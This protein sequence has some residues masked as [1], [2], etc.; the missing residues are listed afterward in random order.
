MPHL[1][2]WLRECAARH[3]RAAGNQARRR[4][5]PRLGARRARLSQRVL[6][7]EDL[8]RRGTAEPPAV[9]QR[10]HH[11][12]PELRRSAEA[13]AGGHRGR[14]AHRRPV[15]GERR[16]RWAAR[17]SS[18][19]CAGSRRC[20]NGCA[21][22]CAAHPNLVVLGDFNIAPDDRDVHDPKRWREKILCSTPE[23]E[24]LRV[25]ARPRPA[26]QLPPVQRRRRAI[27]AGGI[28]GWRRSSAAG[29]CA[30]T[31]CWSARPCSA[32][33]IGAGIDTA[34][35]TLGPPERPHAGVGASCD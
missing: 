24:A 1:S 23:R 17:S 19:S 22:N 35:R 6:R 12:D 7:A 18:T 28:T 32:R 25:A 33:C 8:Q 11:R 30:S 15:R 9:H 26:R 5:L 34:P 27:T 20:A 10:M 31:W 2:Q 29:G 4:A 21:R 3:R 14:P 13:R 16:E